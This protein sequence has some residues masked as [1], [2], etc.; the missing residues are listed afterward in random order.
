MAS[1][2]KNATDLLS[3]QQAGEQFIGPLLPEQKRLKARVPLTV[4]FHMDVPWQMYKLGPF[5]FDKGVHYSKVST[6]GLRRGG[7]QAIFC[8]LYLSDPVQSSLSATATNAA[9]EWQIKTLEDQ[10]EC[11]IV[12]TTEKAFNAVDRNLIPLFLGLEGG[13]LLL[14]SLLRLEYLRSRGVRYLTLTHNANTDWADSA[15][16]HRMHGGL[17]DFGRKVVKECNKLGVYVDVSH[18][19]DE[20]AEHA[21]FVSSKPVLATHSGCRGLVSH[22]RNLTDPMIKKIAATRGLIGVPFAS[23]FVGPNA[24]CV[25]DHIQYIYDLVG[26]QHIAIG[27]DMDG[28]AMVAE[29][30]D[31]SDWKRIVVDSLADRKFGD[32][33]IDAIAGGNIL[34]LME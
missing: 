30:R 33:E 12:D 20:T 23:K 22:P 25:A 2:W 32:D 26:P 13:R 5:A 8:A 19:S 11:Y 3:A 34:R 21:M 1:N 4:D 15:T 27:S 7:P 24:M 17:T 16:D 31:V 6:Q 28:A 10:K 18:A 9:I 14:N 29:A